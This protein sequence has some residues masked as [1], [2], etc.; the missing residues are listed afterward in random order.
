MHEHFLAQLQVVT[1]MSR[2]D[3]GKEISAIRELQD[4][5]SSSIDLKHFK[6]SQNR[7]L[8]TRN[9]KATIGSRIRKATAEPSE[10]VRVAKE[11]NKLVR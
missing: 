7:S 2:E 9:L 3:L 6:K 10:A 11:L 4:R 8:R 1:P 5:W